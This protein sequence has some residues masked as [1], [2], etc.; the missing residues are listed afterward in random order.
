MIHINLLA[1]SV[2]EEV[3]APVYTSPAVFQGRAFG[4]AFGAV[5]IVLG[6]AWWLLGL[7]QARLDSQMAAEKAEANRLAAVGAENK[8]YTA[9]LADMNRRIAAVQALEDNRRGPVAFMVS[10]Q[11]AVNRAPALY[12]VTAASKDGRIALSGSAESVT[13]VA[14]LVG[15]L[16]ASAG[17][18]DVLLREYHEDDAK[19]GRVFFKFGLDFMFQPPAALLAITPP[20]SEV[21]PVAAPAAQPKPNPEKSHG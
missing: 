21:K 18:S 1:D 10:L 17:Y 20:A 5:A 2:A 19:D 14:D 9:E 15:A 13:A 3:E 16:E 12:L 8:R 7:W 11:A 4:I 6:T